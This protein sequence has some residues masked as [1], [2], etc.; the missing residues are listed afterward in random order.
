MQIDRKNDIYQNYWLTFPHQDG[1]EYNHSNTVLDGEFVIDVD[2]VSGKVRPQTQTWLP[3]RFSAIADMKSPV[4]LAQHIP[5][6]L[7]FDLLV[8]DSENVMH[9]PLEKRYGVSAILRPV[10]SFRTGG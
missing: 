3:S 8:L 7:V 4:L 5:R 9:R 6:L 1:E 2:P 10:A